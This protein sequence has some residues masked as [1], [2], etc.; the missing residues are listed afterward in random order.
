M[1]RSLY[2]VL[3]AINN[4]HIAPV[5]NESQMPSGFG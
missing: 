1:A 3:L 5:G 4:T 2:F